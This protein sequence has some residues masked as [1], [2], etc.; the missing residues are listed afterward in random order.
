MIDD[1]VRLLCA[2]CGTSEMGLRK[3]NDQIEDR[4]TEFSH[5]GESNLRFGI[6]FYFRIPF[7]NRVHNY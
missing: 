3:T 6:D 4:Q 5:K 2:C 7:I 1:D